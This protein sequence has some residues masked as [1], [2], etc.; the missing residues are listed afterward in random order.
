MNRII[1][2]CHF[3][4]LPYVVW[5]QQDPYSYIIAQVSKD[6]INR[7]YQP[8][9]EKL[10]DASSNYPTK[11]EEIDNFIK[12]VF[13][14]IDKEKVEAENQR[15]IADDE[16]MKAIEANSKLYVLYKRTLADTLAQKVLTDKSMDNSMKAALSLAAY[17]LKIEGKSSFYTQEIYE[18]LTESIQPLSKQDQEINGQVIFTD[19]ETHTLITSNPDNSPISLM[20]NSSNLLYV[21]RLKNTFTLIK[22]ELPIQENFQNTIMNISKDG[23]WL[24]VSPTQRVNL[25]YSQMD[26][27]DQFQNYFIRLY[28][29]NQT[30]KDR[31][32]PLLYNEENES[33]SHIIK[34]IN[35][36]S[37]LVIFEEGKVKEIKPDRLDLK[38]SFP[39]ISLNPTMVYLYFEPNSNQLLF[40]DK[41]NNEFGIAKIHDGLAITYQQLNISKYYRTEKEKWD[42]DATSI[43]ERIIRLGPSSING[44]VATMDKDSRWIA[45][46][47]NANNILLVDLFRK[48]KII[49]PIIHRK[50]IKQLR[51]SGD[52]MGKRLISLGLDGDIIS[53]YGLE[54]D[55]FQPIKI[56]SNKD[57][58]VVDDSKD[59]VIGISYNS[60]SN[61]T[62]ITWH[63]LSFQKIIT[64]LCENF[65]LLLSDEEWKTEINYDLMTKP[66]LNC[67]N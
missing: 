48:R 20:F 49:L 52:G 44:V 57:Y 5:P 47:D 43:I 63:Q 3:F 40:Y 45:I 16:R 67:E 13:R 35:S 9:I 8:A 34:G 23:N 1:I 15:K 19:F 38:N 11:K 37:F 53:W 12:A 66:K 60:L 39:L 14:K 65:T 50:G 62:I 54:E 58:F 2:F 7:A 28:E 10:L 36:Y 46:G 24:I 33:I 18:A 32:F 22:S 42:K 25:G 6:T 55:A 30:G 21:Y 56:T 27:Q 59:H 31:K 17:Q 61:N 51:F 64:R 4:I 29:I 26:L 41:E